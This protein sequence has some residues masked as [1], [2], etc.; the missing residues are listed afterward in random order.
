PQLL[1]G[2][3]AA[4]VD[5]CEDPDQ[6]GAGHCRTLRR[7]SDRTENT[8]ALSSSR[9]DMRAAG[10][11]SIMN[12]PMASPATTSTRARRVFLQCPPRP[13]RLRR[14]SDADRRSPLMS[15]SLLEGASTTLRV[16]AAEPK[17]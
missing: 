11:L 15:G 4:P 3:V 8:I 6:V 16:A 1:V 7:W 2:P 13:A 10:R 9:V 12:T 17:P 14:S 5:R